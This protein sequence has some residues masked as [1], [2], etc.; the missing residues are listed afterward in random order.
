M[1][2]RLLTRRIDDPDRVYRISRQIRR[3][4]AVVMLGLLLVIFS[5]RPTELVAILTVVAPDW[6][7][8]C[9]KRF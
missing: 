3:T 8:R 1:S 7:S 2:I 6:P 9:A 5:P 4:G